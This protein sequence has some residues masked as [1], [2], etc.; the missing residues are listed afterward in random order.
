VAADAFMK[1]RRVRVR[2]RNLPG[3]PSSL[4]LAN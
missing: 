2:C 1:E 4:V 3:I